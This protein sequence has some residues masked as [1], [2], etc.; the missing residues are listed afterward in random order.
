MFGAAAVALDGKTDDAFS[1]PGSQSQDALDQL[2]R[3]FPAT[4]GSSGQLLMT[5][6]VGQ[7]V[8]TPQVKQAVADSIVRL[9]RIDQ[10]ATVVSPYNAVVSGQIADSRRAVIVTVPLDVGS[11]EVHQATRDDIRAVATKAQAALPAGST[12]D[13]GG[14]AFANPIPQ[15]SILEALGLAVALMTLLAL[16]RS[17]LASVLPLVTALVGIGVAL[18]LIMGS[19]ALVTVSSTA[20]MLALM[21]GL[22]VGIDYALLIL[23][24]HRDQLAGGMAVPE[25]VARATA[26]AGTAVVF[27]G[28][29][30]IIAV[31]G[32]GV[33][34]IP[35]L[36]VMGVGAAVAVAVALLVALTLVPA[37]MGM[38]GERLRPRARGARRG[39]DA[40]ARHHVF[41]DIAHGWVTGVTRHPWAAMLGVLA[42]V[43][44]LAW[45]APSLRLVLPDNGAQPKT[46]AVRVTYDKIAQE[47]G[48]GYNGPLIVTADIVASRDPLGVMK[49]LRTDIEA[50]E[51]VKLVALATPN[52]TADTGI[53]QVIPD[54][55]PQSEETKALVER[56]RARADEWQQRYGVATAVT[57]FTAVG[58]DVSSQL[59]GSLLP[60]GI[61]VV[62]LSLLLLTL[63]FRSIAVPI[64]AT[65]GY[66]LSIAA[67]FGAT[68]MVFTHGWLADVFRVQQVGGVIS[69][70]PV[71]LMGL[72]F[73]LAMDYEVFIVS[74]IAEEYAHTGDADEAIVEGFTASAPVVTAAAIIMLSVFAAF[75]PADNA[76][77]KPIAFAL[78]VGVAVDAFLVRMTLVPAVLKLLGHRAWWL[79][80]W[81]DRRLPRL[82]VEGEGVVREL[83]LAD[84]PE[85]GSDQVVAARGVTVLGQ[86]GAP[87]ATLPELHLRPGRVVALQ[88]SFPAGSATAYALSGRL[89]TVTGDLKVAGLVLPE[90][91]RSVRRRVALIAA[92]HPAHQVLAELAAAVSDAV[93]L[94][95]ID[96]LDLFVAPGVRPQARA[97]LARYLEAGGAVVAVCHDAAAI[98]DLVDPGRLDI[99]G[100]PHHDLPW[101]Q[102]T[103]RLDPATSMEVIR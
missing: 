50:L 44:L 36:T 66:I 91:A 60:F 88:S 49:G 103:E 80:G 76:N 57:G 41:N 5:V 101:Q 43:A 14:A 73:G 51:G 77:L 23:S 98:A 65:L 89:T 92:A 31:L 72:L 58:I 28:L 64:K 86:A 94:I 84:W 56:I 95:V 46:A 1:I 9:N 96:E 87:L 20:P 82:D 67:A 71:L 21:L 68:S 93:A 22:A 26:T 40:P 78:T 7:S 4:A 32:L 99:T 61:V 29:T 13:V 74:R 27:A 45:P 38:A 79:P 30:V 16:F 85:P 35:F 34:G 24:R 8:D 59:A 6:P 25:S 69:F 70:L 55:A 53:V 37:T 2:Q 11:L 81:L 83:R 17:L 48:P 3:T 12:V 33:V 63:V 47:F 90:R 15:L 102:D 54:S 19:A 97:L 39:Q 100:R 18:S 42:I 62:G 52:Q 75:V 10:V